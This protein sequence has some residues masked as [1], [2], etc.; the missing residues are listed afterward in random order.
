CGQRAVL[1][2]ASSSRSPRPWGGECVNK[3][4]C[5][6]CLG[7]S[8]AAC[9]GGTEDP[10]PTNDCELKG[11]TV[12]K[13]TFDAYPERGFAMDSCVDFGIAKVAVDVVDANGF[14]T[15]GRDDC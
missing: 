2:S 6:S 8:L 4:V 7:V 10:C 14:S 3:L 5:L 11:R 13:W 9:G 15:S 1:R 12:V